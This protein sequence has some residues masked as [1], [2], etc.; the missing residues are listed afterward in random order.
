MDGMVVILS[1]NLFG[2]STV[3]APDFQDNIYG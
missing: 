2:S 3:R 1:R